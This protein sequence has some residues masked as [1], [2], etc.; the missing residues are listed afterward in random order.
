[1][2]RIDPDENLVV[3]FENHSILN[4]AKTLAAGRLIDD[5]VMCARSGLPARRRTRVYPALQPLALGS[6]IR[7]PAA[8]SRSPMPSGSN[9]SSGNSRKNRR[10]PR[11]ARRCRTCRS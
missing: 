9:I 6:K 5:D 2:P 1:M 11:A 7:T 8:M 3:L 10:R 4:E